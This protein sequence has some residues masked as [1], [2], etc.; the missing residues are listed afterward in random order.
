[1]TAT[2]ADAEELAEQMPQCI[3][4]VSQGPGR[5]LTPRPSFSL[6]SLALGMVPATKLLTT[7]PM[8]LAGSNI[9]RLLCKS[10][11]APQL[12]HLITHRMASLSDEHVGG[13]GTG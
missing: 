1:M 7:L 8:L 3:A 5:R 12:G 6:A 4:A 2:P 11:C 10:D 9:Q 13:S